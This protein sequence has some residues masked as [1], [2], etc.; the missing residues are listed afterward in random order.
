MPEVGLGLQLW[1]GAFE[2]REDIWLRWCDQ[3]GQVIPTG[4][5]GIAQE[6][7]EKALERQ[8]KEI[9]IAQLKAL[10]IKPDIDD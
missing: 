1:S 7:L 4:Q 9:L 6:R 3:T 5:E 2:G 10:G 8:Q